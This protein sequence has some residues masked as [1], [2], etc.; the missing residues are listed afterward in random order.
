MVIAVRAQPAGAGEKCRSQRSGVSQVGSCMRNPSAV[1]SR[2]AP[3]GSIEGRSS[4]CS[5]AL[6]TSCATVQQHLIQSH[7]LQSHMR[8]CCVRGRP[9]DPAQAH[10]I[11]GAPSA[12]GH[13]PETLA[14]A[15]QPR[16]GRQCR[17]WESFQ[18]SGLRSSIRQVI[19]IPSCYL[20]TAC[21]LRGRYGFGTSLMEAAHAPMQKLKPVPKMGVDILTPAMPAM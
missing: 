1:G 9:A 12:S 15:R 7:L 6:A 20:G 13:T 16:S 3:C 14:E 4:V 18:N 2:R 21:L 5:S 11:V 10:P 17:P 19:T 8:A